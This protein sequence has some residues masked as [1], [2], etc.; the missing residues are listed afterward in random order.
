[1]KKIIN[2]SIIL[3]LFATLAAGAQSTQKE[4]NVTI[5]NN[6]LGVVREIRSMNIPKGTS[7][8]QIADVPQEIVPATVK[9]D[10]KGRV[11]EQNYRFDIANFTSVLNRYKDQ[12]IT[13]TGEKSHSGKL[14]SIS[15]E[16]RYGQSSV[17]LQQSDG[18]LILV[19]SIEKYEISL[20]SMPEGFVTRPTLF[21]KV[22]SENGGMQ[23]VE[24]SYQTQNMDWNAEY[25]LVLNED[26]T[27]AELNSWVSLSNN[28][29]ATFRDA[30]LKLVS[31]R[32]RKVE[33]ERFQ[34]KIESMRV[35]G[36]SVEIQPG[37]IESPLF[38][39]HI[40]ELEQKTTLANRET[41]QIALF[42][43]DKIAIEKEFKYL[44]P[45][46]STENGHPVVLIE[47]V[48][49]KANHLGDPIPEGNFQVMKRYGHGKVLVGESPIA[50]TPKDE[51]IKLE[52]GD[53]YDVV[54][55]SK[56][57]T[58]VMI[59]QNVNEKEY[60]IKVKN[61]K[62]ESLSIDLFKYSTETPE[63]VNCSN[64]WEK[65][66]ANSIKI[67]VQLDSDSEKTVTLKVR[68][69]IPTNNRQDIDIPYEK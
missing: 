25:I 18:S 65:E 35:V 38:E 33:R 15:S 14:I 28:S 21:W 54:I 69:N 31:G 39:Y 44:I 17:V 56:I 20:T 53:A 10:F 40:Y 43:S 57:K 2:Q 36:C 3:G 4:V 48:N 45:E 16:G 49:S 24:L 1:M 9:I 23:D 47:F 67:P 55:E 37:F 41:K 62:K 6:N 5:F 68:T 30:S 61:H 34:R 51:K 63:V 22:E 13:L 19:P 50:H 58:D 59:G 8:L 52:V 11:L 66:N 26:D 42:S 12:S 32:I 46:K 27:Q 60:E 29:G 64:K 7:E